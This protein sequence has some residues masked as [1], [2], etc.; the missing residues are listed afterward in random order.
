MS[1]ATATIASSDSEA[2]RPSSISPS[3]SDDDNL[4]LTNKRARRHSTLSGLDELFLRVEDQ[5]NLMSIASLWTFDVSPKKEDV[6]AEF[7]KLV[8]RFPRFAQ[9]VSPSR[10][11]KLSVWEDDL[12]FN[13]DRHVIFH[14]PE[15]V[16]TQE[17]L[18]ELVSQR[19][20]TPLHPTEAL[21]GADVFYNL[22]GNKAALLTRIHHCIADGQGSV[23]ML[24]T[25]TQSEEEKYS[26]QHGLADK[27]Q[28][29]KTYKKPNSKLVSLLLTL[30]RMPL[31][32]FVYLYTFVLMQINNCR[33][34]FHKRKFF[35]GPVGPRKEIAWTSAIALDDVKFVKDTFQVSVND[36]ILAT[37]TGAL[38]KYMLD[39]A[40]KGQFE[41]E[42]SCAVP[43][44]MRAPDDWRLGNKATMI[45]TFLPTKLSTPLDRLGCI[46]K[47]M[48]K[49]KKSPEPFMSYF[50]GKIWSS[51]PTVVSLSMVMVRRFLSNAHSILTNVPGPAKALYFAGQQISTYVPLI[52]QPSAGGLGMAIMTYASKV[53]FGVNSDFGSLKPNASAL[54]KNFEEEFNTF[55]QLAQAHCESHPAADSAKNKKTQ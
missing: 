43:V 49:V 2:S 26:S 44:S 52:P 6:R 55:L 40:T 35:D 18:R 19:M 47:R 54:T 51:F 21:W 12:S 9:R 46:N 33:I 27:V 20:S 41:D 53:N 30:I 48:T 13:L 4:L 5:N 29:D 16:C 32:F 8:E 42:I 15:K 7:A 3:P 50:I 25:L 34:L 37:L 28:K 10:D 38:R 14:Q 39:H 23:R 24:L 31:L 17:D 45:W 11:G 36:V 22:E 1:T